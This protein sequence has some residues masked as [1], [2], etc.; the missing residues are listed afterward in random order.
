MAAGAGR[1]L[2]GRPRAWLDRRWKH[3]RET[4]PALKTHQSIIIIRCN[5]RYSSHNLVSHAA[6]GK[7]WGLTWSF[8]L[9]ERFHHLQ[10]QTGAYARYQLLS[11]PLR[12]RDAVSLSIDRTSYSHLPT[13]S[14]HGACTIQRFDSQLSQPPKN[15]RWC[16]PL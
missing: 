8:Q 13:K 3:S 5:T 1:Q 6:R 15:S 11:V 2:D 7:M 10:R 9:L 16:R 14:A 12:I 4:V